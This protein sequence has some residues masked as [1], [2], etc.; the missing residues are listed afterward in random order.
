MY[1]ARTYPHYAKFWPNVPTSIHFAKPKHLNNAATIKH[2]YCNSNT[3][4]LYSNQ[5]KAHFKLYKSLFRLPSNK[6][7]HTIRWFSKHSF[8]LLSGGSRP[9]NTTV[10]W[11]Q[12]ISAFSN[13]LATPLKV[14]HV[15]FDP[16][17]NAMNF[18]LKLI[19]VMYNL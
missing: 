2:T 3:N 5:L 1:Y 10:Y 11:P 12:Y 19:N 7:K 18:Y 6:N 14:T 16:K 13:D 8:Y 9:K 15:T 17:Q 4:S